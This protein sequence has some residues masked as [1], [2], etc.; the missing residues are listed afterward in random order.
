MSNFTKSK[1]VDLMIQLKVDNCDVP[2]TYKRVDAVQEEED[3]VMHNNVTDMGC[4]GRLLV[5]LTC[6][7]LKCFGP[8]KKTMLLRTFSVEGR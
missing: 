3:D 4:C 2:L 1:L 5:V 7:P 8:L 6:N